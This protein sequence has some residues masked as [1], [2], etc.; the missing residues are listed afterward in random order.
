M[1]DVVQNGTA[2][3]LRDA[4]PNL[5]IG[6]KTGT[7]DN[8]ARTFGPGGRLISARTISRTATFVFFVGDRFFGVA[9]AYVEGTD[10]SRYA[11]TSG[12]PVRVVRLLLPELK[13]LLNGPD[14]ASAPDTGRTEGATGPPAGHSR[15]PGQLD[16]PIR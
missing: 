12:L 3:L 10:A 13:P 8:I 16:P 4:V 2:S 7:G 11:F 5:P 9:S 1:E 6:G 15:V 14:V